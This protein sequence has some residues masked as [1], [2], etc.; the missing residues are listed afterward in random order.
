M[1]TIREQVLAGAFEINHQIQ[2]YDKQ[3]ALFATPRVLQ[4]DEETLD[5]E[6]SLVTHFK[7]HDCLIEMLHCGIRQA[8]IEARAKG[9][10]TPTK[11]NPNPPMDT[12][13]QREKVADYIPAK[14]VKPGKQT[15]TVEQLM[16]DVGLT[17]E[18]AE[19]VIAMGKK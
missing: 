1:A 15:V 13:E 2:G 4:I 3:T 6:D 10:P 8:V 14:L 11:D 18:Q 9:R 17:R 16:K 19:K 5:N 12:V 7:K